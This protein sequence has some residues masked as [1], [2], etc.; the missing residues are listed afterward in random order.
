MST[1]ASPETGFAQMSN[2][3]TH[4]AAV[5]DILGKLRELKLRENEID[6]RLCRLIPGR[7]AARRERLSTA[8]R[9]ARSIH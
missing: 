9:P 8:F 4:T 3:S 2:A 7:A 6:G 1:G 5:T